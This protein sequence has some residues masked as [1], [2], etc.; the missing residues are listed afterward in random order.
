LQSSLHFPTGCKK[1]M[2]HPLL[3]PSH[4]INTLLENYRC[5]QESHQ[6]LLTALKHS[7][8]FP[9]CHDN[10]FIPKSF[11]KYNICLFKSDSLTTSLSMI[12]IC[13]APAAAR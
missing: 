12:R 13:P 4:S 10:F 2:A 6:H 8:F 1:I 7:S 11:S 3:Q 9:F 5:N